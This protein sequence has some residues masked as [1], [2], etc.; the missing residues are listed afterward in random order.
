MDSADALYAVLLALAAGITIPLGGALAWIDNLVPDWMRREL[1]HSVAAFGGGALMSAIALVL[2]PEGIERVSTPVALAVFVGGGVVFFLA[3]AMIEKS[4]GHNSQFMAMLLDYIPET[5]ALGAMIAGEAGGKETALL[6][7]LMIALQ[8]LPEGFSAFR[9]LN[10][11]GKRSKAQILGLF[12]LMVPIG[13]AAA[14]FGLGFLHQA[15]GIL[16]AIMLFASGGILYLIFEDI[17]PRV[18]L[19]Y[20]WAPPLGAVAG[21]ALGL[22]GYLAIGG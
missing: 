14:L 1:R 11:V 6:L 18:P 5:L 22:A 2:V 9:E 12:S 15:P 19:E 10:K 3:D 13:P 7:A 20:N 8:N 21:F 16:G 17:A 4:G